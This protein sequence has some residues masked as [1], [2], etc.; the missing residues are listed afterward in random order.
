MTPSREALKSRA[1][2]RLLR[3][4]RGPGWSARAADG[5]RSESRALSGGVEAGFTLA[6]RSESRTKGHPCLRLTRGG[7][8]R[9]SRPLPGFEGHQGAGVNPASTEGGGSLVAPE[10]LRGRIGRRSESRALSGG[11]EAG[12]TP[13]PRSGSRTKG[14]CCLRLTRG[15]LGDPSRPLSRFEGNLGAGVNPAS[16]EGGGSLVAT[17]ALR[18]VLGWRYCVSGRDVLAAGACGAGS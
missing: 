11:V 13:A 6:P 18:S 14:F 16:A 5:R 9:V 7:L 8:A 12:F 17:W 15:G 1:R 10:G 3:Q 2:A 4:C